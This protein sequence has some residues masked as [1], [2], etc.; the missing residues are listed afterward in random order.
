MLLRL[1]FVDHGHKCLP[2]QT[3]HFVFRRVK[4]SFLMIANCVMKKEARFSL[5]KALSLYLSE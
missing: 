2:Q 5:S 3:Q 4:R 1:L